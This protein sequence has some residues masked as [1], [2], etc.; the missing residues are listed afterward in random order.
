ARRGTDQAQPTARAHPARLGG[1]KKGGSKRRVTQAR[2]HGPGGERVELNGQRWLAGH[3]E[4]GRIHE[5]SRLGQ[6]AVPVAPNRRFH[7][8][9]EFRPQR[10]RALGSAVDEA[11]ASDAPLEQTEDHRA[12]SPTSAEHPRRPTA[13]IPTG[14]GG[15]EIGESAFDI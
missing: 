11:Y 10:R 1:G 14:P 8:L 9:A 4:R 13:A 6:K 15:I 3:A 5:Q 7:A 2:P 12:R